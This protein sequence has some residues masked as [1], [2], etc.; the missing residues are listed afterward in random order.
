MLKQLNLFKTHLFLLL[1]VAL[2]AQTALGQYPS[3]TAQVTFSTPDWTFNPEASDLET[4]S[5]LE[6]YLKSDVYNVQLLHKK[7]S[8]HGTQHYTYSVNYKDIKLYGIQVKLNLKK[9]GTVLSLAQSPTPILINTPSGDFP[10]TAT[11]QNILA[12]NGIKF[13]LLAIDSVWVIAQNQLIPGVECIV[14]NSKEEQHSY[15]IGNGTVLDHVTLTY[16]Y[17]T[18]LDT[19]DTLINTRIFNPDP[20]TTAQTT[21]GGSYVDNNDA[22]STALEAELEDVEVEA[23]YHNGIFYLQNNYVTISQHSPPIEAPETSTNPNFIYN[24]SEGG[25]EQVMV[26]YH[27]TQAAQHVQS[28]GYAGVDSPIRADANALNGADNSS[29]SP[30]GTP[31]LNFG[32]GGV[33]DAEDA[34]VIVHEYGHALSDALAPGTNSGSERQAIDEG[35]GDYLAGSYS[36][37]LSSYNW[38]NMFS[39]DGH[40]EYWSGRNLAITNHYP[41][42]LLNDIHYDGQMWSSTLMEIHF[43]IGREEMDDILFQ[44]MYSYTTGMNMPQAAYLLVQ[45]DDLINNGANYSTLC[46]YLNKRGFLENCEIDGGTS[47]DENTMHS[48]VDISY[49]QDGDQLYLNIEGKQAIENIQL[50]DIQGRELSTTTIHNTAYTGKIPIQATG[51]VFLRVNLSDGTSTTFKVIVIN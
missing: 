40:N 41:E 51:I 10:S 29:Y 15:A 37:A 1:T 45:A 48:P 2:F 27:I 19:T 28:V 11:A 42:D 12:E 30:F 36:Y 47:I 3:D 17:T 8:P 35:F 39:W 24:R 32:T 34:D 4:T 18:D 46:Y 21:Y 9:D 16:Y 38:H 31:S 50:Y 26:L 23:V 43:D 5:L 20:L 44:S 25:F 33:D 6:S 22:N 14:E 49:Y 7:T 13:T